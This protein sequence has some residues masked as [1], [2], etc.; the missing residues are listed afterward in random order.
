MLTYYILRCL[1]I[2][3]SLS[4]LVSSF[5]KRLFQTH[6]LPLTARRRRVPKHLAVLFVTDTALDATILERHI[7]ETAETLAGWCRV[8]GAEKLTLYDQ[9]GACNQN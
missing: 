8:I 4:I 1:H 5:W 6:P 3:H 2:L 9:E 7:V